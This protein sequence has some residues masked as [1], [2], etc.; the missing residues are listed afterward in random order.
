M[1]YLL[2]LLLAATPLAGL[3][4]NDRQSLVARALETHPALARAA[5]TAA[6]R[7]E[8]AGSLPNPMVMTGVQNKMIDLRDDAMMTMYM[9]GASQTL[10]R[11]EKR[12]ARR[13]VAE[14]AARA[15]EQ[16]LGS[17]RAEIERDVLLAWYELAAADAELETTARVREM[18]DAVVAAARDEG[19]PVV[20]IEPRQRRGR[21][22]QEE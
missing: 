14:L 16:E 12:D 9:I 4:F 2:L 20:E 7:I 6:E 15:A 5:A 17:L 8:P 21:E 10:V 3:D 13:S 22:E 11:P 18:I 19:L 1:R